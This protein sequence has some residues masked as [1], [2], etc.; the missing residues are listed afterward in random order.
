MDAEP[1]TV[2]KIHCQL[3]VLEG[4]HLA[5]SQNDYV[6]DIHRASDSFAAQVL[7][8]WLQKLGCNARC[9]SEAEW[10]ARAFV[11][12]AVEHEPEVLAVVL[13]NGQMHV[14]IGQVYFGHVIPPAEH[15]GQSVCALHLE[16]LVLQIRIDRPKVNASPKL[17]RALLCHRK[18]C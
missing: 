16:V 13:G 18:E 9:R 8:Y 11:F 4:L 10:H 5:A 6:V 2:Q 17:V 15:G 12:Y 7:D 14:K 1:Q 3:G